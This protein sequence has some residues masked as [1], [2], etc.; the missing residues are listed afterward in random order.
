M[1]DKKSP[2][3]EVIPQKP[4]ISAGKAQTTDILVRITPPE[5]DQITNRPHLNLALVLDRSGSMEGDK[6]IRARE[7]ASFCIDQLLFTDRVSLVVFD[8][9]VEVLVEGQTVENREAIKERI[10]RIHARNSTALHQAWVKGGIEV[11]KNL[12][13]GINRVLLIT[14][15]L[16]NVGVTNVDTIVSQAGELASRGVSTSTIGIGSDFNEDLLIPMAE[17]AQGNAWHVEKPS[18]MERI[19][20]IELECLIAQFAH[21]VSLGITPS[22]GAKVQD[23][24]NDFEVTHTGRYK[25]PNLRAGSPLDIVMR[26]KVPAGSIGQRLKV[27]DLRLAWN[28]QSSP[29]S[30]REILN[31]AVTVEYAAAD[32]VDRLAEDERV[33]KAVHFLM[34]ARARREAIEHLDRGDVASARAVVGESARLFAE[35]CAAYVQDDRVS[36][37]LQ[38]LTELDQDLAGGE[39]L[40]MS[41]KKMGYQSYQARS[42]KPLK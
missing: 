40:K 3:V 39:D 8:D 34:A 15:G 1:N 19:F 23:L 21:T 25:L 7:A 29:S 41:R 17:A 38:M 18:D 12:A 11:S 36:S 33:T 22:D 9:V 2:R 16:A 37:E 5:V 10:S 42:S 24:L 26:L 6:M 32:E 20:G 14:D 13:D 35:A 28:P 27:L 30:D 31:Q 4:R